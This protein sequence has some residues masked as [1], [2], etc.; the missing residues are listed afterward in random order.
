MNAKELLLKCLKCKHVLLC[1]N[2]ER[3]TPLTDV[4][5]KDVNI[6]V[7]AICNNLKKLNPKTL[8]EYL[9][10]ANLIYANALLPDDAHNHLKRDAVY[11]S[12]CVTEAII[13]CEKNTWECPVGFEF[14][15]NRDE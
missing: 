3:D 12:M 15:S 6:S 8:D 9:V 14:E 7:K 13:G 1:W 10:Y 11:T 5:P 4:N 2:V